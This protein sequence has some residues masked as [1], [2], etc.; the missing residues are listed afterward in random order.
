MIKGMYIFR[1]QLHNYFLKRKYIPF[2]NIFLLAVD[3]YASLTSY[4]ILGNDFCRMADLNLSNLDP[5]RSKN[6]FKTQPTK[7][8]RKSRID[9][10]GPGP[11]QVHTGACMA[12]FHAIYVQ[13]TRQVFAVHWST[14]TVYGESTLVLRDRTDQSDL[15]KIR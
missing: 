3:Q 11:T 12:Q 9:N 5:K 1:W 6:Q 2:P 8:R 7:P 10:S 13:S 15:G 14:V 4:M